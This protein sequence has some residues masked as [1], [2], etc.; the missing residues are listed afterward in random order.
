MKKYGKQGGSQPA[1]VAHSTPPKGT[2]FTKE[3]LKEG[4]KDLHYDGTKSG[5]V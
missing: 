2:E 5:G 3:Q 4:T 1:P